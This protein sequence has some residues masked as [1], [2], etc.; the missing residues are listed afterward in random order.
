MEV[1]NQLLPTVFVFTGGLVTF[2]GNIV[3]NLGASRF[4]RGIS[5][6]IRSPTRHDQLLEPITSVTGNVFIGDTRIPVRVMAP[7]DPGIWEYFNEQALP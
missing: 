6:W 7:T 1:D 2:T 5:L 3:L 4:D